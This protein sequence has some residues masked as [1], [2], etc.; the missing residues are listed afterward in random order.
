MQ[1]GA[2][3][4]FERGTYCVRRS[5]GRVVGHRGA[6]MLVLEIDETAIAWFEIAVS[7]GRAPSVVMGGPFDGLRYFRERLDGVDYLVSE[8]GLLNPND[9]R[10]LSES[11]R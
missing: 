10:L 1:G 11:L 2:G 6:T 9:P 3:A 8:I 5:G 7:N 4:R